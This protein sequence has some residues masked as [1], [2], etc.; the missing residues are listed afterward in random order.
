MRAFLHR[1]ASSTLILAAV[2]CGDSTPGTDGGS[3]SSDRGS[4]PACRVGFIGDPAMPV[5]MTLVALG[6]DR[7]SREITDGSEVAMILPPQGGR[8]IFVGARVSNISA[9]QLE[10][11]GSLR[12]ATT[13]QVRVDAR[14]VNLRPSTEGWGGPV[15][16]DI[17]SFSNIP[18]CPNQWASTA[19]YGNPFD[20]TVSI[21]DPDGRTASRTIQVT[22][23]CAEP[24]F[25]AQ[26]LCQCQQD[27][28]LGEKC[29]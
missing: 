26:C 1:F 16:G 14:T 10:L 20:L 19:V 3:S 8:V 28:M 5:E 27:Y 2:G 15:D 21:T 12:D 11:S 23:T 17:S 29:P 4:S 9:C 24:M 7:V 6:P 13:G 25:E 22:P 18:L